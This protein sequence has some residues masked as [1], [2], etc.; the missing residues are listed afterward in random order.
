MITQLWDGHA[1]SL[2]VGEAKERI[3]V[4]GHVDVVSVTPGW[5]YDPFGAELVGDYLYGRGTQDMKTAL[6]LNLLALRV[7]Q[8]A[9]IPLK[10]SV[11]L[12]I[13]ADEERTM[14]D[15]MYY[16]AHAGL[17][18]FAYTPDGAFPLCLGE[19][20][21]LCLKLFQQQK[22]RI[23]RLQTY[24]SSN[25]VCDRVDLEI[26]PSDVPEFKRKTLDNEHYIWL[27]Q[28]TISVLGVAAHVARASQGDS[29]LIRALMLIREVLH[30]SWVDE[31][32]FAFTKTD[33]R[34]L[35]LPTDV[36][37]MGA[38]DVNLTQ[39]Q[40]EEGHIEAFLDIRYPYG[41]DPEAYIQTQSHTFTTQVVYR[42][43]AIM[44]E[45][46]NPFV[47]TLLK[48]YRIAMNDEQSQP[49]YSGQ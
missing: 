13:G 21:V 22:S 23:K 16:L 12:V 20:G 48:T 24:Q 8:R 41:M 1:V 5:T 39:M 49:Y 7:I 27:N 46:N 38:A 31:W 18:E 40:I 29:A 35:G 37:P 15:L 47:Q 3:E 33:G 17:P 32:L 4:A 9:E 11:R 19:K 45:M 28:T 14:Q 42:E 34:G 6:W 25:I 30:E 26:A 36:V 44:T 10:R 2:Q 43:P